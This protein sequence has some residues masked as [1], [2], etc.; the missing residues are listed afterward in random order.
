MAAR[1]G[2]SLKSGAR[3]IL[4][5]SKQARFVQAALA[6]A[7]LATLSIAHV[8]DPKGR[9]PHFTYTGPGWC[10]G[11]NCGGSDDGGLA[12][13]PPVSFPSSSVQLLSWLPCPQFDIG[14]ATNTTANTVEGYVSPGGREY[15]IIGLSDGTGFVDVTD[16]GSPGI[17][18][19]IPSVHSLW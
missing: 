11:S 2:R 16:P 18:S 1:P 9:V 15:A 6:G 7:A 5:M 17:R 14:G 3:R 19:F 12:G 10:A 13:G 8:D 4:K